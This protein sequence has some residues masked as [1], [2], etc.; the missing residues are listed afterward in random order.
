MVT[1][2]KLNSFEFNLDYNPIFY[3]D[4]GDLNNDG[5]VDLVI[6]RSD[7]NQVFLLLNNG[8]GIFSKAL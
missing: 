7:S 3:A 8:E 2:K 6:S 5:F 1:L 4:I